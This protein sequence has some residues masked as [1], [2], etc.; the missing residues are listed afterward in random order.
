MKLSK[1]ICIIILYIFVG[2]AYATDTDFIIKI[3]SIQSHTNSSQAYIKPCGNW[4]SKNNCSPGYITWNLSTGEGKSMYAA[5]LN[6][7]ALNASVSVR[8]DG[9]SCHSYDVTTMIRLFKD[10]S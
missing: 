2:N 3:C 6:A 10:E 8:L 7:F 9:S 5:A 4:T 1:L